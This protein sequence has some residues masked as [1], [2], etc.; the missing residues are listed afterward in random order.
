MF[1]GCVFF[2]LVMVLSKQWRGF[3]LGLLS[4]CEVFVTVATPTPCVMARRAYE[5]TRVQTR[6]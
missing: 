3:T 4:G 6:V 2:F 5:A 1:L